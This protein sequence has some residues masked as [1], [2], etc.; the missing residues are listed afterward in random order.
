LGMPSFS[1]EPIEPPKKTVGEFTALF[2]QATP[3]SAAKPAS[4]NASEPSFTSIFKDMGT[5]QAP[6]S[7]PPAVQGAIIPPAAP[8]V[9]SVPPVNVTPLPDPVFVAPTPVAP[10]SPSS[11]PAIS[12]SPSAPVEK[13]VPSRQPLPGDGATGAFMHPTAEPAP[14]PAE[15]PSGPSP[16]TQIISRPKAAEPEEAEAAQ[17]T[18][19]SPAPGKFAAPSMPKIP[20]AAPPPMPKMPPPPKLAAP[21]VPKMKAPPA[22]KVPKIDAPAPPPVSMW[23]LIITLTVLFFLAVIL[24]LYFVLRH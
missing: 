11:A 3:P 9:P 16:Y 22:P 13:P 24:V 1:S 17:I 21:P 15:G 5:Q 8:P 2:G 6:F 10:P 19:T 14:A 7:A 20:P 12:V 18:A 23:P 4:P